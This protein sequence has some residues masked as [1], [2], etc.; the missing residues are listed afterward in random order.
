M[1]RSAGS[2]PVQAARRSSRFDTPGLAAG[3]CRTASGPDSVSV[4]ARD[5]FC[6]ST[7]GG[8]SRNRTPAGEGLVFSILPGGSC[9][10]ISRGATS[11]RTAWGTT[12]AAP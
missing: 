10:S 11:G 3:S 6:A 9:R 5:T 2:T 1:P 8:S 12:R 4:T 7:S